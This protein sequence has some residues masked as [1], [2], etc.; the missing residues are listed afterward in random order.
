M[1]PDR[2][3]LI[4]A[5]SKPII[6]MALLC[7]LNPGDELLTHEPAWLSYQEHA[8]LLGAKPR[9]IPYDSPVEKFEDYFSD[10]TRVFVLNNP[11]NPAGR[12]YRRDE[13][14]RVYGACRS[15]GIYLMVDEAYSDFVLDDGFVSMAEVAPDKDGVIIVNSLSKNMGMSGWRIGYLIS[16]PSF[17]DAVLKT[18]Q[19]IITC[20]PT[21]LLQ[22]CAYYF[23]RIIG[24]TLPQVREV[25]RKRARVAEMDGSARPP[26]ARRR[27]HLLLLRRHRILSRYERGVRHQAAL[28]ALD[29]RGPRLG[30][31]GE[32]RPLRPRLHRLRVRGA[33][34]GSPPDDP[35]P[36]APDAARPRGPAAQGPGANGV[37]PE[38]S[39]IEISHCRADEIDALIAF[40]GEQWRADHVFVRD[41]DFLR[42]HYDPARVPEAPAGGLSVLLARDAGTIVGMLGLNDVG[43][44]HFGERRRGVWTSIWYASPTHRKQAVGA[45]LFARL[46]ASDYDAICMIG[47]NPA[48]RPFF[49]S[50]G[51]EL[52]IDT[53]RWCGVLDREAAESLLSRNE[54]ATRSEVRA[55]VDALALPKDLDLRADPTRAFEVVD[56]DDESAA[57][58][59][60]AWQKRI[61][62]GLVGSD[63]PAEYVSWRYL[64]HPRFRYRV[65]L[66]RARDEGSIEGLVATRIEM[67]G[68]S[69]APVLRIVDLLGSASAQRALVGFEVDAV[70]K[71][72]VAFADYHAPGARGAEPLEDLGLRRVDDDPHGALVPQRFQPLQFGSR[73]LTSAFR[74]SPELAQSTGPLLD[75]RDFAVSRA[76][77]D[78]DRPS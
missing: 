61:A 65:R 5:G 56:W 64:R 41:P 14:E 31:R 17:V 52:Q 2:E 69:D 51:Y 7:S 6:Y 46:M 26:A 67:P 63:K 10:A 45:R 20:A 25:V 60:E 24:V 42:W 27:H 19:H 32:H 12:L 44:N 23:E 47:M 49:Q 76:D 21:I 70:R 54:D 57:L 18:N 22:Y 4:S 66:A 78:Q 74:L 35:G 59:D 58:W 73:P 62:P 40:I 71:D 30:L 37:D 33:D 11:N 72:A 34:L 16:N 1:D 43:F 8:R 39:V 29:R 50:L 9:F 28:R 48:V 36:I 13:L 68:D 75:R 3:L 15:R 55:A 53:P 77:G 38:S